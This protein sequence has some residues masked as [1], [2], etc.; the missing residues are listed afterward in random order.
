[1]KYY[2]IIVL[3]L[4]LTAVA[5]GTTAQK[6]TWLERVEFAP[7]VGIDFGAAIPFPL[8]NV[9]AGDKAISPT[10]GLSPGLRFVYKIDKQWAVGFDPAYKSIKMS[11]KGRVTNQKFNNQGTLAYFTGIAD[12]DMGFSMFEFPLYARYTLPNGKNR[13]MLGY[14]A[15]LWTYQMFNSYAKKGFIGPTPDYVE[16]VVDGKGVNMD[17][18]SYLRSMEHGLTLGYEHLFSRRLSGGVRFNLGMSD[19]FE[20]DVTYFDFSFLPI[21]VG[22]MVS[23]TLF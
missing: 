1:M 16:S 12:M 5:V 3:S 4:L 2:R 10:L 11:V 20:P 9:P 6:S 8:S 14:Y 23:Y 22:F 21:R 17:F 18:T 7:Q 13:F 19:I 15:A